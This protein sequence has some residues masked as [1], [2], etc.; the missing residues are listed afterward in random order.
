MHHPPSA[1]ELP[2]NYAYPPRAY[3]EPG[4]GLASS[5]RPLWAGHAAADSGLDDQACLNELA[6]RRIDFRQLSGKR[7]VRLPV[8]VTSP[9]NGIEYFSNG[10]TPLIVDCRFAVVLYD[11]APILSAYGVAKVR[12]SGAYSYRS[13]RK[14]RLSLHAYGLALDAHEFILRDGSVLRVDTNYAQGLSVHG[15][16]PDHPLLNRLA[17]SFKQAGVFKE[18]LTPD[19]NHDHRDH[20]HLAIAPA[21]G[22]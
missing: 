2:S 12:F 15:C 18:M 13:T 7:G 21:S 10:S 16:S 1:S 20:F 19:Y 11:V 14:G 3:P 4:P 9:L 22:S 6:Q 8:Q 17:C 5:T